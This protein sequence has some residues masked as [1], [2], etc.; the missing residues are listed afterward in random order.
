[1][2]IEVYQNKK[3]K[4]WHVR[5]RGANNKI[6]FFSEP[7]GYSKRDTAMNAVVLLRQAWKANVTVEGENV[8]PPHK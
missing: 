4:K 7:N 1:M 3:T 6:L 2:R 8:D 5:L